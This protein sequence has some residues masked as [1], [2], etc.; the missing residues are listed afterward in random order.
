M[1]GFIGSRT[2][3]MGETYDS[4][5]IRERIEQLGGFV[6]IPICSNRKP[7]HELETEPGEESKIRK[8]LHIN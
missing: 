4:K 2:A 6:V 5:E 8:P 3:P 7:R 1:R